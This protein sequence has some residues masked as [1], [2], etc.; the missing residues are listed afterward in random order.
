M[1][2]EVEQK[3]EQFEYTNGTYGFKEGVKYIYNNS[4][5][6]AIENLEAMLKWSDRIG[7]DEINEITNIIN[8]LKNENI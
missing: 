6:L 1:S 3:A 8:I 4:I 7:S 5:K 2:E